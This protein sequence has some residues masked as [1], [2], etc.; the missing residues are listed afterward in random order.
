M[1]N[2]TMQF[3]EEI[4]HLTPV[5]KQWCETFLRRLER[6]GAQDFDYKLEE[7]E[8][9][10]SWTLWLHGDETLS[11]TLIGFVQRF[12]AKHRPGES[13]SL[14]FAA[15]CS[16]PLVGEF[17]GGAVFI[18]ARSAVWWNETAWLDQQVA[19]F[20]RSLSEEVQ[21]ATALGTAGTSV[22]TSRVYWFIIDTD[23][24]AYPFHREL[25]AYVVGAMPLW[26]KNL[27]E[28][29]AGQFLDLLARGA[30]RA[31]AP[32]LDWTEEAV[33]HLTTED[34]IRT[35]VTCVA[36]PGWMLDEGGQAYRVDQVA[37]SVE[38]SLSAIQSVAISFERPLT[39]AEIKQ[40]QERAQA[41]VQSTMYQ[42]GEGGA[43][44]VITG[45]RLVESVTVDT[46][47]G[48]LGSESERGEPLLSY[49]ADLVVFTEEEALAIRDASALDPWLDQGANESAGHGFVL[50]ARDTE[51]LEEDVVLPSGVAGSRRRGVWIDGSLAD[52][53]HHF[54]A[55]LGTQRT[56]R[57]WPASDLVL[58][59]PDPAYVDP[60][61]DPLL[62]RLAQS[63]TLAEVHTLED[64][65]L[66]FVDL[67]EG[68]L[69]VGNE[70]G[71]FE[72]WEM[73]PDGRGL[74]LGLTE[75]MPVLSYQGDLYSYGTTYTSREESEQAIR[76]ELDK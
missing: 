50:A 27:D 33:A 71:Q 69:I 13:F 62:A 67:S 4:Q 26:G 55:I 14:S 61:E 47:T 48:V 30:M 9:D 17:G 66:A 73:L 15:T 72:T 46:C 12:L 32:D 76:K 20:K 43:P 63:L 44:V 28:A 37:P 2:F 1:P 74:D 16:E 60:L 45:Y 64:L 24:S 23:Q 10:L 25:A 53:L 68:Y 34:G 38:A 42:R 11:N 57:A 7:E 18:T 35:P 39:P 49:R 75:R 29:A 6:L 36:T 3:S 31:A 56:W 22:V 40:L 8:G 58:V 21:P 52:A 5:E 70:R 41:F 51:Q 54:Q 59:V 19:A 65:R